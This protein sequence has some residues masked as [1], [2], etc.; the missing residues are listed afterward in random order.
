MDSLG[1][2]IV[3]LIEDDQMDQKLTGKA[4]SGQQVP[5]EL[6]TVESCEEALKYLQDCKSADGQNPRPNLILLDLRM[7]GMDGKEFLQW[8]KADEDLSDI[9]V[10]VLTSS[11]DENDIQQC[12]KLHAAGYVCKS[13][14]AAEL[15]KIVEKL[16]KY[17]LGTSS[18][19]KSS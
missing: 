7:P 17:W 1:P 3:L 10:V 18:L 11:D 13:S 16:A 5:N 8:I 6:H 15:Q 9:P 14:S 4:L 2:V 12:Y 19:V